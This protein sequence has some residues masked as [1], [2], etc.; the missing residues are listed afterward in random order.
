VVITLIRPTLASFMRM[1]C[2]VLIFRSVAPPPQVSQ[3]RSPSMPV[4]RLRV[5]HSSGEIE[6]IQACD[7]LTADSTLDFQREFYST[8]ASVWNFSSKIWYFLHWNRLKTTRNS[9]GSMYESFGL[10]GI[11]LPEKYK[12]NFD[13]SSEGAS[14]CAVYNSVCI[15]RTWP[16]ILS[17]LTLYV[18]H[19]FWQES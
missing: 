11:Q 5:G 9:G 4:R 16:F 17:Y 7:W 8:Q 13:V 14:T 2:P 12:E 10:I 19:E 6:L 15:H 18:Y 3:S 1:H